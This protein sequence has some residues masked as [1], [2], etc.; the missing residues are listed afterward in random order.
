ML[1][2]NLICVYCLYSPNCKQTYGYRASSLNIAKECNFI[3]KKAFSDIPFWFKTS[4]VKF[5][6][7]FINDSYFFC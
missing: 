3:C 5:S 1:F 7:Y 4:V 6:S 2:P